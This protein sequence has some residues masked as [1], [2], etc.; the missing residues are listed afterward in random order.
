DISARDRTSGSVVVMSMGMPV[1]MFMPTVIVMMMVVMMAIVMMMIMFMAVRMMIMMMIVRRMMGMRLGS[2]VVIVIMPMVV[3]MSAARI[4][5][6]FGIERRLD[7]DHARPQPLHHR[8]DHVIPADAQALRHDLGRQMA[9]A[10]MPGD[11]D[12][13]M[14]IGALDLDQRLG[15][16]HHLDQPSILQHQR[17]TTAKSNGVFQV[18]QEFQSA[19]PSHRHPPPVAVVEIQHHGVG[20]RLRPAMLPP[21]LRCAD[22]ASI[23]CGMIA[24]Q[25]LRVCRREN[26]CPL[27]A[28]AVLWV[29]IM[30]VSYPPWRH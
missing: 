16:G 9:V 12:Q 19:R 30:P 27:C 17:V 5:A 10:E 13:M 20:R 23:L 2:M 6:A 4:G 26:R 11:A 24:A 15:C 14:R 3:L 28:N 21:D 25:T 22:H 7:L 29:R 18:E 8:L 1:V